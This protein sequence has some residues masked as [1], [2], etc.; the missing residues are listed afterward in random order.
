[1]LF[2]LTQV[3]LRVHYAK[4]LVWLNAELWRYRSP[5]VLFENGAF[6]QT[7]GNGRLGHVILF[8]SGA[9]DINHRIVDGGTLLG[10]SIVLGPRGGE[11]VLGRCTP[12]G[13]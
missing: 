8:E 1:M 13:I 10:Q 7:I 3:K 5:R 2:V 11:K 4:T 12:C 9:K 6:V